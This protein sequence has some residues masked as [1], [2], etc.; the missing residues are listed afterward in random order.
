M[1][2]QR[3]PTCLGP[4]LLCQG[5]VR[6][7]AVAERRSH[8][9]DRA[10]VVVLVCVCVGGRGR[11]RGRGGGGSAE[12]GPLHSVWRATDTRPAEIMMDNLEH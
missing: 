4:P 5:D 10:A 9:I 1:R 6:T 3:R 11:G 12:L 7:R 8:G 2:V